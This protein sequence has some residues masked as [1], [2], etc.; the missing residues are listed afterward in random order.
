MEAGFIFLAIWVIIAIIGFFKKKSAVLSIGGGL[1]AT[2]LIFI[3]YFT[4]NPKAN[5]DKS[6]LPVGVVYAQDLYSEYDK[7]VVA[8]DQKYKNKIIPV[9]GKV[10]SID[11]LVYVFVTLKG[12]M[13][14]GVKGIQ[15]SFSGKDID[16]VAS[17]S[18]G[19]YV[20]IEGKCQGMSL[21][22]G[23]QLVNCRIIK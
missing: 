4:I 2:I 12:K 16:S 9:Y 18:K 7:N 22:A 1:L 3:V 23:V 14:G 19:Q 15:C 8:A 10:E 5:F 6:S 21:F 13:L 20:V 17:L 11:K